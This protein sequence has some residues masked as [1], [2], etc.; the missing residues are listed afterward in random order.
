MKCCS[1]WAKVA[2]IK[3]LFL[4]RS[5]SVVERAVKIKKRKH[6]YKL[7]ASV[8]P[9]EDPVALKRTGPLVPVSWPSSQGNWLFTSW[10]LIA[11]LTSDWPPNPLRSRPHLTTPGLSLLKRTK[12]SVDFTWLNEGNNFRRWYFKLCVNRSCFRCFPWCL[13]NIRLSAALLRESA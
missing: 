3:L 9:F 13:R 4:P 10:H 12:F 5:T 11:P 7:T 1:T 8:W 2:M 6:Q